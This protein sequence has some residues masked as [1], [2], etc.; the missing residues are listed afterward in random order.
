[1]S[2]SASLPMRRPSFALGTV[3]TL[4]TINREA[5][6]SPFDSPGS[7]KILPMACRAPRSGSA[8]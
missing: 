6:S 7:T 4:S 1:M 8:R 5:V 2:S 3:V